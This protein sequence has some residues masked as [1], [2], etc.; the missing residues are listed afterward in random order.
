MIVG[1]EAVATILDDPASL[2]TK[3]VS[4][5]GVLEHILQ[6]QVYP[7]QSAFERVSPNEHLLHRG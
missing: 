4:K 2:K 7:Q 1:M 3:A 5:L 6:A